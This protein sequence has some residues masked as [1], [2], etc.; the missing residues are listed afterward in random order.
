MTESEWLVCT[1]VDWLLDFLA[2]RAPGPDPCKLRLFACACCRRLWHLLPDPRSRA[3][4]VLAEAYAD[5]RAAS[6]TMTAARREARAAT[7]DGHAYQALHAAAYVGAIPLFS[8]VREGARSC[9]E[10]AVEGSRNLSTWGA[11]RTA[12]AALLHDLFGNPFRKVAVD[13]AWLRWREGMVPKMAQAVY[14]EYRFGD[15]PILADALEEAGCADADLLGHC[16]GPGPHAR[17]CWAVDALRGK[18]AP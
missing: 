5:G 16:R 13:P 9:A 8:R 17:G 7:G 2:R 1:D 11:E 12:Q 14:D 6:S 3:V 18:Q 4:V 10:T 15:L